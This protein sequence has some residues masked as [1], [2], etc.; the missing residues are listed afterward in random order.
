M[1]HWSKLLADTTWTGG[2]TMERAEL[3]TGTNLAYS[4]GAYHLH[5]TTADRSGPYFA[6]WQ[7]QSNGRWLVIIDSSR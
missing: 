6:V 3:V 2:W 5:T 7:K 1:E 4:I